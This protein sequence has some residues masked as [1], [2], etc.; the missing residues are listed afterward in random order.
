LPQKEQYKTFSLEEPFFSGMVRDSAGCFSEDDKSKE[1]G[2]RVEGKAPFAV[3]FFRLPGAGSR[4][5]ST[6]FAAFEH[7][8]DQAVGLG[9]RGAHEIV[10]LGVGLDLLQGLAG[11]LG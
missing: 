2:A 4:R 9:F 8:V 1:N 7:A 6:L 3:L 5:A 11:A 10:P